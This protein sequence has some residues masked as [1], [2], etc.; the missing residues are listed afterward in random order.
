MERLEEAAT[1][2]EHSKNPLVFYVLGIC[3]RENWA[4][5][6]QDEKSQTEKGGGG[7]F[8]NFMARSLRKGS[9]RADGQTPLKGT[10]HL[11][12]LLLSPASRLTL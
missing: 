2:P 11:T 3:L 9:G 4:N 12:Y 6:L 8:S 10:E 7:G 5:D 1:Q